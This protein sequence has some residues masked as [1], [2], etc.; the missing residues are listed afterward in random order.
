MNCLLLS[1]CARRAGRGHNIS[2]RIENCFYSVV[3]TY[4]HRSHTFTGRN[5]EEDGGFPGIYQGY[6]PA[7]LHVQ[8]QVKDPSNLPISPPL[9]LGCLEKVVQVY[10]NSSLVYPPSSELP[11]PETLST[12]QEPFMDFFLPLICVIMVW[13]VWPSKHPVAR[14][15][16]A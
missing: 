15:A 1:W 16:I 14:H 4:I 5:L 10:N 8:G 13:I 12:L 11:Q 7:M 3:F 9:Q 2:R 6:S